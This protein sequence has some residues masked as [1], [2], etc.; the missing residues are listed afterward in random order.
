MD[1]RSGMEGDRERKNTGR[2]ERERE[3]W[4]SNERRSRHKVN[5][6]GAC[7]SQGLT[8]LRFVVS[9]FSPP[10]F[11]AP[12]SSLPSIAA[13]RADYASPCVGD[14]NRATRS[15]KVCHRGSALFFHSAISGIASLA[16]LKSRSRAFLRVAVRRRKKMLKFCFVFCFYITFSLVRILDILDIRCCRSVKEFRRR[17]ETVGTDCRVGGRKPPNCGTQNGKALVSSGGH[18][19]NWPSVETARLGIN[20]HYVKLINLNKY[21]FGIL[22][23]K[24]LGGNLFST[25]EK[26][27]R[28]FHSRVDSHPQSLILWMLVVIRVK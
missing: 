14:A 7:S 17:F 9:T 2:K 23:W 27:S 5:R 16:P 25:C 26:F 6:Y 3:E 12:L 20:I 22:G 4:V 21:L 10:R 19:W 11:L 13:P 24:I 18:G 1:G 28:A 15:T 8:A